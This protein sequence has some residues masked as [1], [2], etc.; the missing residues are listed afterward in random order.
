MNALTIFKN[1]LYAEH[2]SLHYPLRNHVHK[3]DRMEFSLLPS[4][5]NQDRFVQDRTTVFGMLDQTCLLRNH[6]HKKDRMEFSL[7]P[8]NRNQDR[9][10]QDRTNSC[11]ISGQIC[12][13]QCNPRCKNI[14]LPTLVLWGG[15]R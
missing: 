14:T 13:F 3:K 1:Y 11:G 15:N 6:V 10:V 4:N 5:R 2:L 9:F 7:L 8:L 12:L